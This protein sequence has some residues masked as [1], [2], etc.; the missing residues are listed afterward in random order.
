VFAD[1]EQKLP[2][3]RQ[4]FPAKIIRA[5]L[6]GPSNLDRSSHKTISAR[7]WIASQAGYKSESEK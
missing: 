2:Y 1:K 7:L 5:P 3:W 4:N 6:S